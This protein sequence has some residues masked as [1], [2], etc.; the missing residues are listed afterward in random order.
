MIKLIAK[1]TIEEKMNILQG[2]KKEL[3]S[4]IL[5]ADE[6]LTST[7]TEQDIREILMI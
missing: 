6:K 1:G 4:D 2:K 7:L 5:Q 3:I